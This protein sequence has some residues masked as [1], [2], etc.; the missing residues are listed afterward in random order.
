MEYASPG[1]Y[2]ISTHL[3]SYSTGRTKRESCESTATKNNN[4]TCTNASLYVL[5]LNIKLIP[6]GTDSLNPV[7]DVM[8]NMKPSSSSSISP[9]ATH[10]TSK[11]TSTRASANARDEGD[12]GATVTIK[13][14]WNSHHHQS[15]LK[16]EYVCEYDISFTGR[17]WEPF[18]FFHLEWT[19]D[20]LLRCRNPK[21]HRILHCWCFLARTFVR[22][23]L[24]FVRSYICISF[25]AQH[26][27]HK[28]DLPNRFDATLIS[29]PKSIFDYKLI[30][31]LLELIHV[32]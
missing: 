23:L 27:R 29:F 16:Y 32:S 12:H 2:T 10:S 20:S 14:I 21:Q 22:T 19:V 31:T 24:P 8:Q 11:K 6:P 3:C 30:A 17:S 7:D 26:Q 1:R 15:F 28:I 13:F 5:N 25:I 9:S 4:S 18:Y